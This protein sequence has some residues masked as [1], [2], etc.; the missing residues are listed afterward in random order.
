MQADDTGRYG[1]FLLFTLFLNIL[2]TNHFLSI[3]LI[4]SIFYIFMQSFKRKYI[5]TIIFT[6]IAF[7]VIEIIQ[8]F[9][10]LSFTIISSMILLFVE[11]YTKHIFASKVIA[12][13]LYIF[14]FYL[15]S[16][17]AYSYFHFFNLELIGIL[18]I[19]IFLDLLLI[20]LFL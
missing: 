2:A 1:V 10:L 16:I 6:I 18:G 5:Y 9:P 7:M 14:L 3:L 20:G 8:G 12:N 17:I 15:F 13:V 4:G 11:P 19:N